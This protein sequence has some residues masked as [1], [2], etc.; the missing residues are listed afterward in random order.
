MFPCKVFAAA[1]L[2]E[3]GVAPTRWQK[4][5]RNLRRWLNYYTVRPPHGMSVVKSRMAFVEYDIRATTVGV[6]AVATL[7]PFAWAAKEN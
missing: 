4:L 2:F 3:G 5:L 6:F 7:F 1:P